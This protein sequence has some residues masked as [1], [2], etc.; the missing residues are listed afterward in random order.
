MLVGKSTIAAL[1]LAATAAAAM[2]SPPP[3]PKP[4]PPAWDS[5]AGVWVGDK[6]HGVE[7]ALPDPLWIFGYGSLCFKLDESFIVEEQFIGRVD[8][9]ARF[10]AQRSADHRGTPAA[11]GLVAT[12]VTAEELKEL[13]GSSSST[14]TSTSTIGVCYRIAPENAAR[15][16]DALDFREKGGYTRQVVN[17]H[18]VVVDGGGEDEHPPPPPPPV[19]ALLYTATPLNPGFSRE[20]ILD[21]KSAAAII[22]HAKGP[23]GPNI[24]YL[25][26]LAAWLNEHGLHDPH[27]EALMSHI[28]ALEETGD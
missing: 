13:Q 23:S 22:K 26:G 14:S 19:R 15:L 27:V 28:A 12:L 8:G 10:F 24:D 20:A 3:P 11:P 1:L 5:A 6:A 25:E 18:P 4:P 9:W 16:L 7:D 21:E 17:V 2:S